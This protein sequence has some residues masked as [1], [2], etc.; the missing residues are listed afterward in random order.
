M[1]K[2]PKCRYK[3]CINYRIRKCGKDARAFVQLGIGEFDPMCGT[4]AN[5]HARRG[6]KLRE[7]EPLRSG[8]LPVMD[9][10]ATIRR[11]WA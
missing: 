4:H 5:S 7:L 3:M 6:F 9:A 2:Q 11:M 1:I 10:G 8:H